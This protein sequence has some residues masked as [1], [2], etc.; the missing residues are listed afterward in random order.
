MAH[1]TEGGVRGGFS[2][3]KPLYRSR[4]F[5]WVYRFGLGSIEVMK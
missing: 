1:G 4:S 5:D 2:L 3:A